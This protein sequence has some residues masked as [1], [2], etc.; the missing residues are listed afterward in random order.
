MVN[1]GLYAAKAFCH[2][3]NLVV[4]PNGGHCESHVA[5]EARRH[6]GD[7]G[8]VG[9]SIV[10]YYLANVARAV[11]SHLVLDA[12]CRIHYIVD[13]PKKVD[14]WP[15]NNLAYG[16][17]VD[18]KKNQAVSWET[19]APASFQG[20]PSVSLPNLVGHRLDTIVIPLVDRKET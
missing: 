1:A 7:K 5:R 10:E 6:A 13:S 9:L 14:D 18:R 12:Q 15:L 8:P 3:Y 19:K 2:F 17:K 16:I 4:V 20:F 11:D